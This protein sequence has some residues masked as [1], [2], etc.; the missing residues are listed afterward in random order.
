[1]NNSN[2]DNFKVA[3]NLFNS[4]KLEQAENILNDILNDNPKHIN[5]INL[6]AVINVNL[7][8][9]DKGIHYFK[10]GLE[11]D[12]NNIA[13]MKNFITTLNR[14]KKYDEA[15]KYLNILY[16]L[17]NK[18]HLIASELTNNLIMLEKKE[19]AYKFIDN[20]LKTDPESEL[21]ILT[22][23]NCLYELNNFG[24][25][26]KF[27]EKVYSKNKNNFRALFRLGYINL[28]DMKFRDAIHYFNEII[29]RKESFKNMN[30]EIALTLYNLGLCYQKI[31]EF[32]LSEKNY[33]ESI[34]YNNTSVDT[35]TNLSNLYFF[36]NKLEKSL[37][38]INEAIKLNP[39]KRILYMNLSNIYEKLGKH[40][41][42]VFYKRISAGTIVFKSQEEYGL[43][44]ISKVQINEKI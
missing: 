31:E 8:R 4:N 37:D 17:T 32:V 16:N 14:L 27:Y 10:Q 25:A 42:S 44:E 19:E 36:Q 21:L 33:I 13:L 38:L 2:E 12:K 20:A 35:Y 41:E 18:S 5:A 23:A 15:N 34:S 9:Y 7:K 30:K 43:Y 11:I 40:K 28:V 1:M 22:K 39:K 26:K 24:E 3:S 6:L 29:E